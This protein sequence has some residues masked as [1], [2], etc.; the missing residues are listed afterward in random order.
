MTD[1]PTSGWGASPGKA[2]PGGAVAPRLLLRRLREAL[3]A[4]GDGKARLDQIVRLI[5]TSMVAEVCSVY[6]MRGRDMLEL[7][8]TEGLKPEAVNNARLRVGEGLVGV[9]ARD[10]ETLK[11]DNA[12]E[13]PEFRYLPETGEEIYSSFL[14]VPIQ[15]LGKVIGVLVVQNERPMLY[16]EEEEEALRLVAMVIAE[17]ADAGTLLAPD[18]DDEDGDRGPF[19]AVGTGASDGVAV[20]RVHLHEPRLLLPN[21]IADNIELERRRLRDAMEQLRIDIDEMIDSSHLPAVGEHRDVMETYRLFAND[22]GWLRRLEDNV[23]TG[24]KAEAAVDAARSD[25]RAKI[26]RARDPYLRERL[27]DMDDLAQRLLRRLVAPSETEEPIPTDA[28]LVARAIGPGELMDYPRGTLVGIVLEEGSP[29]SHATIVARALDIPLVVQAGRCAREA[30]QGDLAIINGDQGH[31]HFRPRRDVVTAYEEKLSLRVQEK[32]AFAALRG[33]PAESTDGKRIQLLINAGLSADLPSL[34]ES[35]AEG[36]GL[37]RT[38]LHFMLN[39]RMPT[40]EEQTS[41]Y[42]HVLSKADGKPVTFRTLD[43]GSDK[44]LPFLKQLSEDNPALGWRAIRLGLDRPGIL[45]M[46]AQAFLRAANGRPLR[47]MFPMVANVHEFKR[48]REILLEEV[49]RLN[50]DRHVPP[51][52]LEIGAMLE[53]PSLVYEGDRFYKIADFISIG[54][55]DL[56]QFFYAADRMNERTA[57]RYSTSS[58]PFLNML[59]HVVARCEANDTD[60]SFCGEAAGKPVDALALAA[61]GIKALSIRPAAIGPVKRAI[62]AADLSAITQVIEEAEENGTPAR[63]A[64]IDHCSKHEIPI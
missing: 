58:H 56:L 41:F 51:S 26:D 4:P 8:A 49:D 6:L 38:E 43:V 60:L 55:N 29:S 21:P 63:Q 1:K 17:I 37:L 20:G 42:S 3:A 64:L 40:R 5:A 33:T 61:V 9:I 19:H 52:K 36:V 12:R 50:P 10:A 62:R 18:P 7:C 24:L 54:G 22:R 46:Q 45:K 16:D 13:H 2:K 25:A 23:A 11:T 48:G 32:Q 39:R 28:I 59:R 31:V 35:G 27:N 14:G 57:G 47:I 53:T 30:N 34:A 44:V 15:R